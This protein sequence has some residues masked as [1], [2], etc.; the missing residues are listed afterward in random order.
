M[1]LDG[2]GGSVAGWCLGVEVW[3]ILEQNPYHNL[4][5]YI[6]LGRASLTEPPLHSC[7]SPHHL[8]QSHGPDIVY[9]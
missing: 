5:I 7:K 9:L 4:T 1:L 8:L 6:V 3:F 2:G